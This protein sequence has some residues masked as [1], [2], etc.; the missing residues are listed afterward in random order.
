MYKAAVLEYG[1]TGDIYTQTPAEVLINNLAQ[2]SQYIEQAG[3]SVTLWFY[4]ILIIMYLQHV[5]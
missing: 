5:T 2:Y 1:S 4:F 3:L